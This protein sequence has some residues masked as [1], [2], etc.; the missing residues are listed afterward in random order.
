MVTTQHDR[1]SYGRVRDTATISL[2]V[3]YRDHRIKNP[4]EGLSHDELM[5]NVES[6]A[7]DHGLTDILPLLKKGA[8]A[9]QKPAEAGSIPELDE[10]DRHVLREEITRRWHHPWAL[11]YTIIFNSIAAA[12]QGWD[13]TGMF[14]ITH[15][16]FDKLT[17][18]SY[19]V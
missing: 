17:V 6:Y 5:T 3:A 14:D 13:Q 9:G 11:Y 1:E 7:N 12:I 2:N 8:L 10:Q 18:Y 16:L 4:L 19:R 15:E